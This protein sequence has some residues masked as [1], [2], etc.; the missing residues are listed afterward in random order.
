MGG[1]GEN[2]RE[3][4]EVDADRRG[5]MGQAM[6]WNKLRRQLCDGRSQMLIDL[7]KEGEEVDCY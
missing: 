4:K 7:Q 6:E 3:R 2:A 1:G 5:L